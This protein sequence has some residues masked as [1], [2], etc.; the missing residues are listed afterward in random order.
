M[1]NS[2][3]GQFGPLFLPRQKR[4]RTVAAS[5]SA[6]VASLSGLTITLVNWLLATH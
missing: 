3:G 4:P 1:A 5:A 2:L 6:A